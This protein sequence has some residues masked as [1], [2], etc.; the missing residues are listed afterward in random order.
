MR[1][2]QCGDNSTG[3]RNMIVLN[4]DS[5]GKVQTMVL[6]AAA[7]HRVFID[8]PQPRDRLPGI[9]DSGFSAGHS[10]DELT[11]ERCNSAHTLQEIQ[12]HALARENHTS[13][14]SDDRYGL[15][16]VQANPVKNLRM[17]SHFVVRSHSSIQRSVDIED[18]R[19]TSDSSQNTVLFRNNSSGGPLVRLN[20]GIAGRIAGGAIFQQRI[21]DHGSKPSTIPVHYF[22]YVGRAPSPDQA[23][24][25]YGQPP[26]AFRSGQG[27]RAL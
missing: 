22:L 8:H 7:T 3:E 11:C 15:P 1:A 24:F 14:V 12:D 18:P 4:Q 17:S 23:P 10:L 5:V 21:L 25:P 20:A 2:L 26:S 19:H 6:P 13:V 16:L 9:E 27:P